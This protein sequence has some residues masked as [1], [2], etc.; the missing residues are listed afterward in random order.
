MAH[1]A[2][3]SMG[4]RET[5]KWSNHSMKV[6]TPLHLVLRIRK[7]ASTS[8][9][10]GNLYRMLFWHRGHFVLLFAST[11]AHAE[12]ECSSVTELPKCSCLALWKGFGAKFFF[13]KNLFSEL[14]ESWITFIFNTTRL[15]PLQFHSSL[16]LWNN[17]HHTSYTMCWWLKITCR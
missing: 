10:L 5:Y 4:T 8:T 2:S 3:F 17:K 7:W 9:P 6:A 12:A 1:L 15:S 14:G 11:T 16:S 13:Q